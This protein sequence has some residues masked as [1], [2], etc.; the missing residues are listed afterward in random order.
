MKVTKHLVLGIITELF[1]AP[2]TCGKALCLTTPSVLSI[3]VNQ[4]AAI[5]IDA[6]SQ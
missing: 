3:Y 1:T 2:R 5:S 6:K 4:K